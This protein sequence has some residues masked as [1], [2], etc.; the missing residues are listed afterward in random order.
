MEKTI[1]YRFT[2]ESKKAFKIALV[3]AELTQ[4]ELSELISVTEASLSLMIN[5]QKLVSEAVMHRLEDHLPTLSEA[6][7]AAS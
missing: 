2:A 1:T 3:K 7:E 4:K 6:L 5:G